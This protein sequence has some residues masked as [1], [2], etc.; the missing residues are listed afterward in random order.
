MTRYSSDAILNKVKFITE[1]GKNMKKVLST[2]I[3][4]LLVLALVACGAK[5]QSV[6]YR[7]ETEQSGIAMVELMTFEA[8]G[9]KIVKITDKLEMDFSGFDDATVEQLKTAF[10]EMT[11]QGNSVDG[12]SCESSF[13]GTTYT[14]TLTVDV[15]S[16]AA[17]ELGDMGLL[18]ITGDAEN[19]LSLKN[20]EEQLASN[21]YTKVS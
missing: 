8:E 16:G 10:D 3:A 11:A 9:D 7:M 21:G 2:I 15:E 18:Q 17:A 1:R 12:A 19:G 5:E 13:S 14:M 6:T 4:V 20:T